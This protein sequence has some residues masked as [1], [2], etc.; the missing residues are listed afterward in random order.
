V[1]SKSLVGYLDRREPAVLDN[2]KLRFPGS[3]EV[4]SP[5]AELGEAATEQMPA[6][7]EIR[8]AKLALIESGIVRLTPDLDALSNQ[9]KQRLRLVAR[10]RLV[11]GVIAAM[12]GALGTTLAI[13]AK[14][15]TWQKDAIALSAS[16]TGMLGGLCTVVASYWETSPNGSQVDAVQELSVITDMRISMDKAEARLRND[17]AFRMAEVDIDAIIQE[18]DEISIKLVRLAMT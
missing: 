10:T 17:I 8:S 12:A 3:I 2:L 16:L 13:V 14:D 4:F 7:Q 1:K 9:L 5:S 18:L 6:S 11:G 15:T